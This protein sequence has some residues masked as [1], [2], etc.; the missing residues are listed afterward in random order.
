MKNRSSVVVDE[1]MI[2]LIL[3]LQ[4]TGYFILENFLFLSLQ[5]L[6]QLK[7]KDFPEDSPLSFRCDDVLCCT[8]GQ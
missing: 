5:Q 3:A 1:N 4:C 2:F 8:E 6:L 7:M